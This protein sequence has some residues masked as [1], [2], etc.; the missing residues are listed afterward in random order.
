M[1][2]LRLVWLSFQVVGDRVPFPIAI[3]HRAIASDISLGRVSVF[4]ERVYLMIRADK[5]DYLLGRGRIE[6]ALV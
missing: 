4:E 3:D 1:V 2:D 6:G 5:P